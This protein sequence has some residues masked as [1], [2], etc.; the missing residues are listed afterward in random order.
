MEGGRVAGSRVGTIRGG[1]TG[2]GKNRGGNDRG[3]G[4]GCKTGAWSGLCTIS[5]I[6]ISTQGKM[7]GRPCSTELY[8]GFNAMIVQRG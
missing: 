4:G 1:A 7:H 8:R 3:K 5:V 2:K 6:D